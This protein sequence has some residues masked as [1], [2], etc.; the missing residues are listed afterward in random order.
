MRLSAFK[1]S[2]RFLSLT[3]EAD[4]TDTAEARGDGQ[5]SKNVTIAARSRCLT[6]RRYV[7]RKPL[8]TE[9]SHGSILKSRPQKLPEKEE[10]SGEDANMRHQLQPA[11]TLLPESH[12]LSLSDLSPPTAS[13]EEPSSPLTVPELQARLCHR[14]PTTGSP[15]QCRSAQRSFSSSVL[16]VQSINPPLRPRLTSTVL[17]P[18]YTPRSRHPRPSQTHFRPS[19]GSGVE[20]A[21]PSSPGGNSKQNAGCSF[22]V[23][24]WACAIPKALPPSP[25]RKSAAWN[26][27]KEYEALLDYTYPLRPGHV[28]SEWNR[29]ELQADSLLRSDPNTKDSGIELDHFWSSASL[30]GLDASDSGEGVSRDRSSLCAEYRTPDRQLHPRTSDVPP[31]STPL[32]LSNGISLS[33]DSLDCRTDR[34]GTRDGY[35]HQHHAVASSFSTAFTPSTTL[36]PRPRWVGGDVDEDFWPLPEQLDELQQLSRQVREVTAQL[37]PPSWT[38]LNRDTSS[39]LSSVTFPQKPGAGGQTKEVVQDKQDSNESVQRS[40]AHIAAGGVR[41]SETLRN[42]VGAGLDREGGGLCLAGLRECL[43]KQLSGPTLPGSQEQNDSL[44]KHIQVFCSQLELLIQQLYALSKSMEEIAAPAG[45]IDSVK[46]S[47]ADY[48]SFQ[49]E[50]S[51]HQPLTACVL[52]AGQHLLSCINGTSPFLRDTLLLI[53]RQSGALQ[54]HSDHLFSSILSAMDT[55]DLSTHHSSVQS[56]EEQNSAGT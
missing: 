34:A 30:S 20:G 27:N 28:T 23:D 8:F 51:S 55:L 29:S 22:Q 40:A 11:Q 25:D 24:Y 36:F 46:S 41:D 12:G 48:Q 4:G 7:E 17:H 47:L 54:T 5:R 10:P 52:H 38:S 1:H 9:E 33:L 19:E 3:A 6:D 49:K 50:V 43:V 35:D 31:C 2:S 16:E 21:T 42:S 45:D 26:P 32:S 13:G 18:T 14:K 44:M 37:S 56:G 15:F 39:I 53:E